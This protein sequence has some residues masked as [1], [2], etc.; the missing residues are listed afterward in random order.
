VRCSAAFASRFYLFFVCVQI[1]KRETRETK[2]AEHST[3]AL[4]IAKPTA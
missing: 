3:A 1:K 4:Q 2:A